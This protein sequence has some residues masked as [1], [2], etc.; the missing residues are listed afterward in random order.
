MTTAT[1]TA[2]TNKALEA[3]SIPA[4]SAPRDALCI[5]PILRPP[6]GGALPVR[7]QLETAQLKH[8]QET[9]RIDE[10][11]QKTSHM[12]IHELIEN[13][14]IQIRT[15]K[16]ELHALKKHLTT[17]TGRLH[18]RKICSILQAIE[19]VPKDI[20]N[21]VTEAKKYSTLRKREN[22]IQSDISQFVSTMKNQ[23][24]INRWRLEPENSDTSSSEWAPSDYEEEQED[25]EVAESSDQHGS[26]A[27][28]PPTFGSAN[29]GEGEASPSEY[30]ETVPSELRTSEKTLTPGAAR[31][32]LPVQQPAYFA[33]LVPSTT[34][35]S[36]SERSLA[37]KLLM[38]LSTL[39]DAS[40]P[41]YVN[42]KQLYNEAA[43]CQLLQLIQSY[44]KLLC[45]RFDLSPRLPIAGGIAQYLPIY[46]I[47]REEVQSKGT[48][49]EPL[50]LN[51]EVG[52]HVLD[53]ELPDGEWALSAINNGKFLADHGCYYDIVLDESPYIKIS[54]KLARLLDDLNKLKAQTV[55]PT[56]E[57][58]STHRRELQQLR[59]MPR[60]EER[61]F[62]EPIKDISALLDDI[63]RLNNTYNRLINYLRLHLY[64]GDEHPPSESPSNSSIMTRRFK[65][66]EQRVQTDFKKLDDE[67]TQSM[68]ILQSRLKEN[69]VTN[70]P[71]LSIR[72]HHAQVLQSGRRQYLSHAASILYHQRMLRRGGT[73]S[74]HHRKRLEG[75]IEDC[76]QF[77][78]EPESGED[79]EYVMI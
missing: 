60:S 27:P 46:K 64:R 58:L 59:S 7:T 77:L 6:S 56:A 37:L 57:N 76:D 5:I 2:Q 45:E 12:R 21:Q 1:T 65:L 67:V 63:E 28:L 53:K 79:E 11:V 22:D 38:S 47:L 18:V 39:V 32:G 17:R 51:E 19:Q 24:P 16:G 4:P 20:S 30:S 42:P 50:H 54:V 69:D 55:L 75:A 26:S 52:D 73:S 34:P 68:Q 44:I 15:L 71:E 29:M 40:S 66:L 33:H 48:R 25:P 23:T 13:H 62:E 72:I 10:D 36:D 70:W 61:G 9:R 43:K 8:R 14:D 78:L 74:A 35:L 41:N 3:I 31:P 49:L